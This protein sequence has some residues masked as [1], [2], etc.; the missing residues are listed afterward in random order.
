M[1]SL[2]AIADYETYEDGCCDIGAGHDGPCAWICSECNGTTH[3]WACG[4][5]P[6]DDLGTGCS[7]CDGTGSCFRCYEGMVSDDA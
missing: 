7:E 4:G 6:G 3:C 5:P 2:D 1:S